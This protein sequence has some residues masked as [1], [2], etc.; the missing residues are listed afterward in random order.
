ML[1]YRKKYLEAQE[2]MIQTI[3]KNT[4]VMLQLLNLIGGDEEED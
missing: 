1:E 3:E 4:E 2:V